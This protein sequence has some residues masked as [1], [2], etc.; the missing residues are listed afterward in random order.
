MMDK[1]ST[2]NHPK[3]KQ[4]FEACCGVWSLHETTFAFGYVSCSR[5]WY[6]L[7]EEFWFVTCDHNL[8][9]VEH[10]AEYLAH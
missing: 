10:T 4:P 3:T 2:I 1:L 5:I 6:F 9:T 7:T 8:K